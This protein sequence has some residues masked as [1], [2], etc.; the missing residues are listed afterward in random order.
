MIWLKFYDAI[1]DSPQLLLASRCRFSE[2]QG[3][4]VITHGDADQ[5]QFLITGMT[6]SRLVEMMRCL[7]LAHVAILEL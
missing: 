2:G 4:L 6:V 1:G 3:G 7:D 5:D